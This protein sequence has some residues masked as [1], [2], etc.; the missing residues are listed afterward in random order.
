MPGTKI[1]F[2][3]YS[4]RNLKTPFGRKL[5]YR[6]HV[7]VIEVQDLPDLTQWRRI[8]IRDPKLTGALPDEIRDSFL[9]NLDSFV[10]LNRGIVLAVESLRFEKTAKGKSEDD[11][12]GV[13]HLMLSDPD[14]HGLLDGGHTYAI[15]RQNR[16]TLQEKGAK[17]YVKVEIIEGFEDLVKLVDARNSSNQ[18]K[19][20]SLM[21]LA[22]AFE[23]IKKV[24][25]KEPYANDIAYKEFETFVDG[26]PKPIEIREIVSFMMA[27]DRENFSGSNHPINSYRS[28]AACLKHFDKNRKAFEKIYPLL[29]DI[30]RLWDTIHLRLPDFYNATRGEKGDV[31]GGRFGRLTGVV[32]LNPVKTKKT[33]RLLFLG[34]ESHYIIP[35]GLKY[36]ILA[37]MR[38]ILED[39]GKRYRWGNGIDP[40][41]FFE[42]G[43]GKRLAAIIGDFALEAQNP[44]KT[45]KSLPVWNSCYQAAEIDYLRRARR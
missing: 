1:S 30:L 39:D 7:A 21:N 12:S 31:S 40:I 25:A 45:G 22:K 16:E 41:E 36:P 6:N 24:L 26:T 28:K 2:P 15:I 9:S 20:E 8:N 14:C 3:V 5:G 4:L 33:Q 10:F 27:M 35:T 42:N 34:Q 32:W 37:A 43:L 29:T 13:L 38:A 44:S 18:V 17:Q 19:D 23:K 11:D